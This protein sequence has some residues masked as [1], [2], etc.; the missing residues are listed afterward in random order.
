[1][2]YDLLIIGSGVI[3]LNIAREFVRRNPGSNI[4]II[5]KESDLGCHSSGRN[6]GVIHAGFYYTADSLKAK[7]T[8]LGNQLLTRYCDE[9]NIKIHKCGK[10]V[11][12]PTEQDIQGLSVL[13]ERAKKNGVELHRISL[14]EAKKIESKVKSA[15]DVLW[16]PT[17][18]VINPIE[19]LQKIKHECELKNVKFMFETKFQNRIDGGVEVLHQNQKIKLKA[20]YIINASGLEAD[21]TARAFGF[22]KNYRILP[23]KGLYLY[24]NEKSPKLNCHIYP[25]PDLANPFLGVHFTVTQEGKIKIGPTAIP[26]LWREQYEGLKNFEFT[27]FTEIAMRQL[28]FAFSQKTHGLRLFSRELKKYFRKNLVQQSTYL[29]EGIEESQF[30][31]WGRAGIRAQLVNINTWQLEMDF[32]VESDS[33]SLHVLNAVSPALTSSMPFAE[34]IVDLAEK[35]ISQG[36]GKKWQDHSQKKI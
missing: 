4:L 15:Q 9:N 20:R 26:A 3:G 32:I 21:H 30:T 22:S 33:E 12:A 36:S 29:L 28:R 7:F 5:E 24:G 6:S 17:T 10:L 27:D 25:V 1:M 8:K 19:L 2:T 23:F 18:S 16:S 34:H 11:V 31:K 35:N 14:S 13:M